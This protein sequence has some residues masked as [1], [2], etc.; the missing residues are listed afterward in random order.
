MGLDRSLSGDSD[1]FEVK[2]RFLSD[3]VVAKSIVREG[4]AAVRSALG[5]SPIREGCF[6]SK[7][8]GEAVIDWLLIEVAIELRYG[9]LSGEMNRLDGAVK[10][11]MT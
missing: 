1:D 4:R 3:E 10:K 9:T 7:V 5:G 2:S 11:R 6:D 8:D